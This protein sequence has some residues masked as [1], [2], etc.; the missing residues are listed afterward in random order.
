MNR[1]VN[2]NDTATKATAFALTFAFLPS[3][4]LTKKAKESA[5]HRTQTVQQFSANLTRQHFGQTEG[6]LITAGLRNWR[7]SG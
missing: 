4:R 2:T 5:S 1:I 6:Q 3:H 7:F